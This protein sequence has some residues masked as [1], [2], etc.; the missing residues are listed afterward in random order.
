MKHTNTHTIIFAL[1]IFIFCCGY[2]NAKSQ[3]TASTQNL[4]QQ[5]KCATME[6]LEWMK[7]QDPALEAKMENEEMKFNNYIASHQQ[8]LENNKAVYILP[9]VVHVV[10]NGASGY[11]APSRAAEQIAQTNSDWA[12]TNG[13]SMEAFSTSL[14]ADC[15]ITLCLATVDPSGNPTTGIDYKTTTVSSFT[16]NNNVKYAS[17]GGA[18]AWDWTKYLNIWVCNLPGYCG[19][20]QFPTSGINA[21]YGVVIHY[22]YFG[23]TGAVAPYDIGGTVSHEFGH[24]FNLYHIW[25]DEDACSGSDYCTDVPNQATATY[26]DNSGVLTDACSPSSPG[27]MYMNFMDY[28]DD[29]DYANMTP[30]QKTRMQSAVST[31]LTSVANNAATACA[32]PPAPVADFTASPTTSC[33]GIIQFTDASTNTPTSWAWTF[34]DGGTSTS[35]NPSYTYTSSGTYTVTLN[36][37]NGNGSDTET[38]T[39][40]ITISLPTAPT[41]TGDTICGTGTASLSASGS[42]TLNWY[43]ASTGGTLVN[44][45][46]TYNTPTISST[47]TYYV[48]DSIPG[49]SY[50]CAKPDNTGGGGYTSTGDHY[51][52]FNCSTPVTLISVKMYGNTTAPGSRTIELRNSTGVV[53]QSSTQNIITGLNTYNLNFDIPAGTSL[54]LGCEGTNIYRNNTGVTYPYTLTGYISVTGSDA[55]SA[56]YY[57]F[58]DWIIQDPACKSSRTPVTA[59][60]NTAS[61]ASVSI[62]ANPTG[63]ICAG[64]SVTFTANATN[65]GTAPTYQWKKNGTNISSATNSTYTSTALANGDIIT[66]VLTSSLSCVTGSP[67]TSNSITMTVNAGGVASVS[68]AANPTGAI[69]SGTSVTYTATPTNGGTP[70]YQWKKNGTNI[71]GAT[72]STYTSTTLAN[73]DIITCV[74]TS[75]LSCATGSP[76]TSNSITMTVNVGGAASVSIAASP[77]GSICSGTSVT[78]TATPTNGGTPTYQWKKNGTNISGA[79]NSTYTSSALANGDVITC[80]MTSSLSCATGSPSTSNSI[81]MTVNAGGA[82]S[83][84][85]AAS[86]T[87]SI[88]AGTSVTFTATPTNGGTPT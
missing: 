43:D 15:E 76:A 30:N 22:E 65:G 56:Y 27:I 73:G 42:G 57:Y 11:V 21:T 18:N 7:L 70:T 69:C 60:V 13:R 31:Y 1:S 12:G 84:S 4:S 34:G 71:S 39:D 68:I 88:C 79:T 78:F 77:T 67:A 63:A 23:L 48:E 41:T 59:V 38:K 2:F 28:S 36:A 19:Y 10:Y 83:V 24:C 26:G 61:A 25:G 85:I 50:N 37:T 9:V 82:A 81:T 80:V 47:T 46:T 32:P 29:I 55:G 62:A 20:A 54:R 53:L 3:N 75:S 35:Q 33:T 66:C 64:T 40:Y 87:G 8:E 44:T 51:L 16:T 17:T 45:G 49:A 58:Y 72:N 86:P 52:I 74:M 14:R 6:H 5:R